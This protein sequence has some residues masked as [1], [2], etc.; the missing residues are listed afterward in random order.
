VKCVFPFLLAVS[1][2]A[3]GEPLQLVWSGRSVFEQELPLPADVSFL[4]HGHYAATVTALPASL[5][6]VNA[7]GE[8]VAT[9]VAPTN[10]PPPYVFH[11]AL[12]CGHPA[13]L[14]VVQ[15]GETRVVGTPKPP[16]DVDLRSLGN[17]T[18]FK[19]VPRGGAG[20]VAATMSAGVGQADVRFVT[21]GPSGVPY[22]EDGRLYFTFSA[23]YFCAHLGV[24]SIEAA[25]PENGWRFEGTI[26]FDYG[27]GKLRNDLA[28]H[29]WLDPAE[30][31]WRAYVSNFSTSSAIDGLGGRAKGGINVAWSR[32]CPL[33]GFHIMRAKSLGLD[34]MNEDPSGYYDAVAKKWR[35]FLSHFTSEGGIKAQLFESDRWDG[36][37]RPLTGIV[38]EDSTGTTIALMNGQPKC[39][40][41]SADRAYYIYAYPTL[42]RQGTIPLN[43]TPWGDRKGWPHGRG[44]PAYAEVPLPDGSLRKI[45]L[46]MDRINFPGMPNPNWTYGKLFIYTEK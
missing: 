15:D 8:T 10:V 20:T 23:R 42:E 44:W 18:A 29:L 22:C 35:L 16:A 33:R 4:P 30:N 13:T 14:F 40:T 36:G 3:Y 12:S 11:L 5:D 24:G 38:P 39:L 37:F 34:G 7:S 43:V 31:V 6:V 25:H 21:R 41:G 46:T 27:D 32:E 28:A 17:L 1:L 19:I 45:F 9:Y 2:S 26:L